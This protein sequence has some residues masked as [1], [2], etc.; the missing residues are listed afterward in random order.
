MCLLYSVWF[1][2]LCPK[3][4]TISSKYTQG[5]CHTPQYSKIDNQEK[6]RIIAINKAIIIEFNS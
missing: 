3:T 2:C 5:V 6:I 4:S 1:I